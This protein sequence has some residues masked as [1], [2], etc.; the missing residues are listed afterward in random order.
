MTTTTTENPADTLEIAVAGADEKPLVQTANGNNAR[1]SWQVSLGDLRSNIAHCRPEAKQ[2]LVDAFLWCIQHDIHKAEFATAIGAS[3]NLMYRVITGRYTNPSTGARLDISPKHLTAI[4]RWLR[5]QKAA[6]TKRSAFIL[7][8]TAKRVHLACNLA[9]ESHTPVMLY[10]PSHIG[11]T[12][13]LEHWAEQNNHGRTAYLRCCAASGLG[14]I[15]SEIASRI[16]VSPGANKDAMI[17]RIRKALTMD[18]VLII[19]ELHLLTNTYRK[20]SFFACIEV[21]RE[22]YDRIGLGMV[23]SMTNLGR[24]KVETEKRRELEQVFRR[25]VHRVQL[26]NMPT[27]G[28]LAAILGVYGLEFPKPKDQIIVS[29]IAEQPYA[30]LRQLALEEG[31]KAI[32]ERIRYAAKLAS[33]KTTTGDDITIT[34]EDWVRAHLT[35]QANATPEPNW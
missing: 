26:A 25:G 15:L 8:P 29:G 28:D 31:L 1:A 30:I 33:R 32:T 35:I 18:M 14:G 17:R 24:D 9:A 34:W 7:T 5:E 16:G 11:K 2:A 10:G 22:F 20:E 13:A 6:A 4:Q 23:L 21:L 3:D 27:R 12:W 19:D